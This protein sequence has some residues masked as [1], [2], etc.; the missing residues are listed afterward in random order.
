MF[1]GPKSV[2]VLHGRHDATELT[3]TIHG[4]RDIR[5]EKTAGTHTGPCPVGG[6][7]R[8]HWVHDSGISLR[9]SLPAGYIPTAVA[10]GD[11]NGDGKLD[12]V[13]ANGG[14]NNL[15]LYLGKGEGT[16][17]LP[18]IIP[19]ELGLSP[20]WIATGDLHGIGRSDLV[21]AEPDSNSVGIFLS[22]GDGTFIESS[23][24]LPDS[25]TFLLVGDFNRDG[26]VDIVAPMDDGNSNVYIAM[27]PG[28]G[29]GTFGSP[30]LTPL[31][32]YVP[33]ISWASSADLNGDGFRDL[34]LVSNGSIQEIAVQVFL[35]KGDGSFT[36]GQVVAQDFGPDVFLTSLLFDAD[37]DGLP[38]A[39]SLLN[40]QCKRKRALVVEPYAKGS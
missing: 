19:V 15:W 35:N 3:I 31:A 7:C 22:N 25:A 32:G 21:V 17:S 2:G 10:T 5:R 39:V 1:V 37:G 11:F 16:F 6:H 24:A 30:V 12:F 4:H 18:I 14:D 13:V 28:L 38:D 20:V 36:A 34:L 9:D 23:V 27:L 40:L 33:W 8:R 26:K 29:N